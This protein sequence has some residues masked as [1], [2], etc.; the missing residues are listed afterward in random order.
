LDGYVNAIKAD[1][2]NGG[3]SNNSDTFLLTYSGATRLVQYPNEP[4]LTNLE[5]YV[6][7]YGQEQGIIAYNEAKS[8]AITK[9]STD[10]ATSQGIRDTA[11]AE[12]N[13]ATRSIVD[14]TVKISTNDVLINT[15]TKYNTN[16]AAAKK[17]LELE[18]VFNPNPNKPYV[19]IADSRTIAEIQDSQNTKVSTTQIY[20][21]KIDESF[22]RGAAIIRA[23]EDLAF[24]IYGDRKRYEEI[25]FV[26]DPNIVTVNIGTD[27]K[28][29]W[30]A[31]IISAEAV[32][33]TTALETTVIV[34]Y[35]SN[36]KK[37]TDTPY[38]YTGI[39]GTAA[40]QKRINELSGIPNY[41]V[42]GVVVTTKN[43]S[44]TS[45]KRYTANNS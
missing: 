24:Q 38:T 31:T 42:I 32:R 25:S 40:A 27:A 2:E 20:S 18:L 22:A 8:A 10:L 29:V 44:V 33:P 3:T 11:L 41:K 45:G 23:K 35:V 15:T 4:I 19:I 5:A 43:T 14:N 37:I 13:S 6:N 39:S 12:Y 7:K 36:G 9:F 1:N 16:E 34:T 21:S 17:L 30:R 28:P 26:N